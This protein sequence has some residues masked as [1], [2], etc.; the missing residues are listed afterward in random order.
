[1][2]NDSSGTS[3]GKPVAPRSTEGGQ[4][5]SGVTRRRLVFAMGGGVVAV[6]AL[7][8]AMKRAGLRHVAGLASG[9]LVFD[10]DPATGA[11]ALGAPELHTLL[12]L[13]DALMPS[14]FT[15]P[16]T[17]AVSAQAGL[18][19]GVMRDAVDYLTREVPGY[20][21]EFTVAARLLDEHALAD[22]GSAFAALPL[23][24]RRHLIDR[25]FRPYA[26]ASAARRALLLLTRD[27]R[28]ARRLLRLTVGPILGEFYSS[29]LGWSA[30]NYDHRPGECS[31]LV[32]YQH[33]PRQSGNGT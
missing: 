30:V 9:D 6:A 11:G 2:D 3:T 19:Q 29:S 8:Y 25:L 15:A 1:M 12:A 5:T 33:A 14:R 13:G 17:A 31:N 32:D 7:A 20:R 10:V 22:G 23:D 26:E 18:A 28:H 16:A 24:A 21:R 27:G 4:A